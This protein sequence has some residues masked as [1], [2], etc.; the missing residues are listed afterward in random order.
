MRS[1]PSLNDF[2]KAPSLSMAYAKLPI[3]AITLRWSIQ[4]NYGWINQTVSSAK[5]F[6][7]LTKGLRYFDTV[8]PI[9]RKNSDSRMVIYNAKWRYWEKRIAKWTH[10]E[11]GSIVLAVLLHDKEI[12]KYNIH[13]TLTNLVHQTKDHNATGNQM[14]KW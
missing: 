7:V 1:Q 10:P 13:T 6:W 12:L 9:G 5:S 11:K 14:V 2:R 8:Q 4:G 3:A